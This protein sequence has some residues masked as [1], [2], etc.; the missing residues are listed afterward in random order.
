MNQRVNQQMATWIHPEELAVNHMCDPREW[1]PV[2]RMK[3]GERPGESS[4]RN[5]A[6]YH[7]V[8]LDVPIVIESDELMADHLRINR[9]RYYCQTKQDEQIGSPECQIVA[10]P[11]GFRHAS[12]ARGKANSFSLLRSPFGHRVAHFNG[13]RTVG[14]HRVRDS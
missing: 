5:A 8:L 3:S 10:D 1:M 9:R 2:C 11:Q 12:L 7:W 14:T 6:I 4:E 13:E